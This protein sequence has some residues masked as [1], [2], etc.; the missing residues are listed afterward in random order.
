MR[1]REE[2]RKGN[3]P[4]RAL[5]LMLRIAFDLVGR[6]AFFFVH[7]ALFSLIA[8]FFV[9]TACSRCLIFEIGI[10]ALLVLRQEVLAEAFLRLLGWEYGLELS[11]GFSDFWL[12]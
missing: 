1:F 6:S 7:D 9:S 8:F 11:D 2:E 10:L 5:I 12:V 4:S 3:L